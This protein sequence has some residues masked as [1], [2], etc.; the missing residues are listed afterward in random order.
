MISKKLKIA[1]LLDNSFGPDKRVL[2]EASALTNAG[3]EVCIIAWDR[4]EL[5]KLPKQ[6]TLDGI[7]VVRTGEKSGRQL[8]FRQI[9]H[10]MLFARQAFRLLYRGEYDVV[11][12]HDFPN[13]PIGLLLKILAGKKV[14]YDAHEIYW[15]MEARKYPQF[16]LFFL[17]WIEIIM[18]RWVDA[19]ITVG[20]KRSDYYKKHLSKTIHIVGNWYNP[21]IED[22][23]V[24]TNFRSLLGLSEDDFIVTYAGALSASRSTNVLMETAEILR[25]KLPN[26]HMLIAGTGPQQNMFE[27]A[28]AKNPNLHY[29]GW[30][31]DTSGLYAASDVLLYL[32]DLSHPYAQFN[33]PNNLYIAVAWGLPLIAIK[34][35]EIDK[36][37]G[38]SVPELLLEEVVPGEIVSRIKKLQ[39]D[40][41]YRSYIKQ[42]LVKLQSSYSWDVAKERLLSA[43]DSLEMPSTTSNRNLGNQ[44]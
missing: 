24:K 8:G 33:S 9:P 4:D 26:V 44:V 14:I 38:N 37:L 23:R 39:E 15:L 12:C 31:S 43:Y 32:M 42:S 1:M 7:Q 2:R 21:R 36:V 10:Y 16:I 5:G 13:L 40:I 11:H 17:K 27:D 6:E 35:G 41:H 34:A 18:I 3:H 29:L 30:L 25:E 28:S 20:Y 22:D 19:F